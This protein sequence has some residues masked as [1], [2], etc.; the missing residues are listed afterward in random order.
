MEQELQFAKLKTSQA[1]NNV[2]QVYHKKVMSN[3]DYAYN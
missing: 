3:V 1:I 2:T